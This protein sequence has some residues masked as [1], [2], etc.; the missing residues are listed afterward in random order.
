[1][2]FHLII[3]AFY[4][5]FLGCLTA[6]SIHTSS[7]TPTRIPTRTSQFNVSMS[8]LIPDAKLMDENYPTFRI[9]SY[10]VSSSDFETW[11]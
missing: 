3:L 1:M 6:N 10:S 8:D 2:Y 4:T 5:V 11:F 9:G 7:V